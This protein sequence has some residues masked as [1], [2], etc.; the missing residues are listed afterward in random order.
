MRY[1]NRLIDLEHL[2]DAVSLVGRNPLHALPLARSLKA[3]RKGKRYKVDLMPYLKKFLRKKFQNNEDKSGVEL[4]SYGIR[5]DYGHG[6]SRRF[7]RYY[8]AHYNFVLTY[9]GKAVASIGFDI[10]DRGVITVKQI[11]G[12]KG[13]KRELTPFRWEKLLLM[14]IVDYAAKYGLRQ[15]RVLPAEFNEWKKTMEEEKTKLFYDVTP[16]RCGFKRYDVEH[17][18]NK[19][20]YYW[21]LDLKQN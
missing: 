1:V 14:L 4:P 20:S 2:L 21:C 18:G 13:R 11:Q 16:K 7:P 10:S 5:L 9:I 19:P 17:E 8:D 15:V 3:F 6:S 12:V